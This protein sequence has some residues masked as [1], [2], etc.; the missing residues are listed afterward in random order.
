MPRLYEEDPDDLLDDIV[1]LQVDNTT[2]ELEDVAYQR[3]QR[4]KRSVENRAAGVVR[5]RQ[6]RAAPKLSRAEL[7]A[8]AAKRRIAEEERQAKEA[9][10]QRTKLQEALMLRVLLEVRR[11]PEAENAELEMYAEH[12][13]LHGIIFLP[14]KDS[15][16]FIFKAS[17]NPEYFANAYIGRQVMAAAKTFRPSLRNL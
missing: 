17:E 2:V 15:P 6:I 8:R 13:E 14:V 3:N 9:A 1:M 5:K 10:K 16:Q 11:M 12:G 7:D 4:Q